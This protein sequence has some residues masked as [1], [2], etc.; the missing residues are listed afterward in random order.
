MIKQHVKILMI[1]ML[2]SATTGT[3]SIA[4]AQDDSTANDSSVLEEIIVT[5]T[6]RETSLQDTAYSIVALGAKELG[7]SGVN[8]FVDFVGSVPGLSLRDQGPGQSR[9]VIRGLQSAGEPLVGVYY[10]EIP[11]TGA[12]GTTNDAGRFS[13]EILL[14]DV[15]RIEVL[16]GPQ[17]TLYGSGSS[18]GTIRVI[19]NKPNSQELEG[20]VDG[21]FSSIEGGGTGYQLKGAV[22]IPLIQGKLAIRA[23]GYQRDAEGFIDNVTRDLKDVNTVKTTGG[24]LAIGW[25]PTDNLAVTGTV[26]IQDQKV[27]S[28]FHINPTLGGFQTEIP[29]LEPFEDETN[30]Y[31]L[32]VKYNFSFADLTYSG[33]RFERDA[34]FN[35]FAPIAGNVLA[36]QPQPTDTDSHELRLTSSSNSPLQWTVGGFISNRTSKVFS[37]VFIANVSTGVV[38]DNFFFQREVDASLDQK[39]IFGEFTYDISER[40]ALT[41][42][43]R[44]FD[45]KNDSSVTL[46]IN[47]GGVEIANPTPNVTNGGEDG[48]TFKAH[49]GYE[50]SEDLLVYGLFSQGFRA[51]GANQNVSGATDFPTSYLS[52]TVD[53]YELGFRATLLDGAMT[54]NGSIFHIDWSN[55][56]TEQTDAA[57]GLF[58]F[59]SNG[60]KADVNGFEADLKAQVSP[61]LG[62]TLGVAWVDAALAE[63][64]PLNIIGE[65]SQT[66]LAG[67][68]IPN[69]P[70]YTL[71][72]SANY[73]RY[74]KPGLLGFIYLNGS[75]TD[76]S[77][78]DYN[79][80]LID[81]A[82]LL[83]SS[84]P[85]ASYAV[86]GGNFIMDL[87]VGVEADSWG[88]S[89]FI[90]NL[91]NERAISNVFVDNFRPAP[92]LNFVE[93]PRTYGIS[94]KK[95]F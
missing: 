55:I 62:L 81:A 80:F 7:K 89:V 79:E 9:P 72:F 95:S 77:F 1:A 65:T 54:F 46:N 25:T 94:L 30:L 6:K 15:E 59:T 32:T 31:N 49:L 23:V 41:L 68:D 36:N 82:T 71:N 86:Q 58:R 63:N 88:I 29:I 12:P 66:G 45:I 50:A 22:N 39:A 78:S 5:A 43:G 84:T 61:S 85:N 67:D 93:R 11:I 48:L 21:E 8:D 42:G 14:Y 60:G 57:T 38:T 40:F 64:S 24:R 26:Y 18:G 73:E 4:Y 70:G 87:R 13:P 69:V 19:T 56:Q 52:D 83:P 53:N 91:S 34:E 2:I 37:N 75:Y 90:D 28:G 17:G 20:S 74:F 76:K 92:G 27:G 3:V 47:F 35:F 10:D 33:S 51:G 44:Y 16:R